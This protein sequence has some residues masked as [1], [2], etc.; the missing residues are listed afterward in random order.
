MRSCETNPPNNETD[1][2]RSDLEKDPRSTESFFSEEAEYQAS[3]AEASL[4]QTAPLL[5]Y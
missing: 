5:T 1:E 4:S 3:I 2:I